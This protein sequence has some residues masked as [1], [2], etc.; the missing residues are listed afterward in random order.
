[1]HACIRGHI[2]ILSFQSPLC[3]Q[4]LLMF[5]ATILPLYYNGR[6]ENACNFFEPSE[7]KKL[8][9]DLI[10]GNVIRGSFNDG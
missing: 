6:D 8:H 10:D 7:N 9:G 3:T 2:A 4:P 5:G 1:M